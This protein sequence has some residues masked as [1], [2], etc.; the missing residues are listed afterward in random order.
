MFKTDIPDHKNSN[1]S[2][3]TTDITDT[4]TLFNREYS[5][6]PEDYFRGM[7]L[8]ERKRSERSKRPFMVMLLNISELAPDMVKGKI[9]KKIIKT[10]STATRE[11]DVKGWYKLNLVMGILFTEF[12][13]ISIESLKEKMV[14]SLKNILTPQQF[15]QVTMAAHSFPE[16]VKEIEVEKDVVEKN[17]ILYDT[18]PDK[19]PA[20]RISQLC[21]RGIDITG[22][23]LGLLLFSFLT[24]QYVYLLA[25][26]TF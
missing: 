18:E 13:G 10:L 4:H 21:K 8:L 16:K 2:D 6:Y 26:Q 14:I 25:L 19:K 1:P 17:A 3:E 7:L 9:I 23:T 15:S 11:I 20:K 22:S 5:F 24:H 12:D